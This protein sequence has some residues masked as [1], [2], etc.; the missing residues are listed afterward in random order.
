MAPHLGEPRLGWAADQRST[1]RTEWTPVAFILRKSR[2][3]SGWP[4]LIPNS[5]RGTADAGAALTARQTRTPARLATIALRISR[6]LASVE[7]GG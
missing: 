3:F 7:V 2:W 4:L 5:S 1:K 6:G